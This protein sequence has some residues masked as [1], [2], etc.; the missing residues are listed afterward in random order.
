MERNQK[1]TNQISQL[2]LFDEISQPVNAEEIAQIENEITVAAH[3]RK[4]VGRK[5]ITQDLPCVHQI[6]DLPAA[7]KVCSCKCDLNKIDEKITE[8]LD[9]IPARA[10]VIQ[11]VHYKYAC[12]SCEENILQKMAVDIARNTLSHWMIKISELFLPLYKLLQHTFTLYDIAYAD[13]TPGQVLKEVD[14][15]AE[16]KSYMWCFIVVV[17]QNCL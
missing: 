2:S 12:K 7:E 17:H 1:R 5:P 8:Q 15:P 11:H 6:H 13:E 10:Q 4:K 9:F 3:Q 16:A 14:R